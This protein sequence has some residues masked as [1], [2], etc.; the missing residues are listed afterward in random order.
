MCQIGSNTP[1]W[2]VKGMALVDSSGKKSGRSD[3]SRQAQPFKYD[4]A[5][6]WSPGDFRAYSFFIKTVSR[7]AALS[8]N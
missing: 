1:V 5:Q 3:I 2:C 6:K 4:L 8:F 7:D